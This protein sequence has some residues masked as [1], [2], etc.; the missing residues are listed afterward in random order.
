[1]A[2]ARCA[3]DVAGHPN[4]T[5]VDPQRSVAAELAAA[6]EARIAR[7][8]HST[9][10]TAIHGK[11]AFHPE[12][13]RRIAWSTY[14]MS[15][16]AALRSCATASLSLVVTAAALIGACSGGGTS[17]RVTSSTTAATSPTSGTR[18]VVLSP[19]GAPVVGSGSGPAS[20]LQAYESCMASH[21]EPLPSLPSAPGAERRRWPP[22][23][24]PTGAPVGGRTVRIAARGR[25]RRVPAWPE[26]ERP[27]G[28]GR[29]Q[30]LQEPDPGRARPRPAAAIP[31]AQ[32][33][34][35][36]HV[37]P[38][39]DDLVRPGGGRY[40]SHDDRP[41]EL[42][43]PDVQGAAAHRRRLRSG[44]RQHHDDR[45][46]SRRDRG[47]DPM[48]KSHRILNVV[49]AGAI[50]GVSVGAY[51]SVGAPSIGQVSHHHRDGAARRGALQRERNRQR[52]RRHAAR[53]Q[54][55][56]QRDRQRD[57]RDGRPARD[58]RPGARQGPEPVSTGRLQRGQDE[59]GVGPGQAGG[60]A[61]TRPARPRPSS[62]RR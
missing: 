4:A 12:E 9:L 38:R 61:S 59:P 16:P 18:L 52:Q 36:L 43:L 49:L 40:H 50:V 22:Q 30:R 11:P 15:H 57:R 20:Q 42:R 34:H 29:L 37:R 62:R 17:T 13:Q 41:V 23:S 45:G 10:A 8:R 24:L 2:A 28:H 48:F 55:P 51:L 47:V 6:C 27:E 58:R 39:R 25:C 56:K 3:R 46:R 33:V 21:G 5:T 31:G 35:Q 26:P 1:M 7:G 60:G 14:D 54:L 44:S 32:R 19:A 53:G